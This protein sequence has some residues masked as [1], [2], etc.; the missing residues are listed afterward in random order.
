MNHTFSSSLI[1]L[2]LFLLSPASTLANS[3]NNFQS[4]FQ[5]LFIK[6]F[7]GDSITFDIPE[8]PSIVGKDMVVRLRGIDTPELRSSKCQG[9]HKLALQ[10][11]NR[12]YSLLKNAKVINLHRTGRGKYFRILADVEF[13]GIDLAGVLLDEKLAVQYFG[14]SRNHDWCKEEKVPP[15]SLQQGSGTLPPLV[16]GIYIWPPPPTEPKKRNK[17]NAGKQ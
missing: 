11:K 3:D 12:V 2:T 1:V 10:A 15:I 9:E 16:D 6:N 13:D 8:A 5:V 14:G 7:D 4:F 17:D